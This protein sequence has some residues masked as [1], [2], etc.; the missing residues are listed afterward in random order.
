MQNL[1]KK[2]LSQVVTTILFVLV[3]IALIA[4][5][6]A[7]TINFLNKQVSLSPKISCI[8]LK[9][10]KRILITNVCYNKNSEELEL[11]VQ[12]SISDDSLTSLDFSLDSSPSS[13]WSCSSTCGN[14]EIPKAGETKTYY[15]SL[16]QEEK[17]LEASISFSS[18]ILDTK[19]VVDC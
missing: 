9:I 6:Y 19:K 3:A 12:R 13:Q 11:T 7:I 2:A 17:P 18:C 10:N 8:D 4:L 15:F 5:L 1:N 16:T 14:C